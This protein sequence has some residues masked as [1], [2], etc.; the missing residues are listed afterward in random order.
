VAERREAVSRLSILTTGHEKLRPKETTSMVL[1]GLYRK[2][3]CDDHKA[4]IAQAWTGFQ[5]RE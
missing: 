1:Q 2:L 3:A 4:S 5:N